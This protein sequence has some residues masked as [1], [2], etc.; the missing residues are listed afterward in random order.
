MINSFPKY[1]VAN[2]L[3]QK[4][5]QLIVAISGGGDSVVLANLLIDSKFKAAWSLQP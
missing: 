3:N 1:L 2:G 4:K 5:D